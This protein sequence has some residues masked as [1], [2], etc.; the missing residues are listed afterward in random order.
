MLIPTAINWIISF[1][2]FRKKRIKLNEWSGVISGIPQGTILSPIFFIIY[3]NDLPH[4]CKQSATMYLCIDY[5]K[6]FR[7]VL[8]DKDHKT[9]QSCLNALRDWSVKC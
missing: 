7:R 8:C 4:V 9:L 1:L 6:L 3:I 2:C 5:A